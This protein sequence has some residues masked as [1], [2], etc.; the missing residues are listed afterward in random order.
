V[1]LGLVPEVLDPVDV[2]ALLD[3]TLRVI[4][5]NMVKVRNVQGVVARKAVRVPWIAGRAS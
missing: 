5:A 3:E 4:D 2:I 1:T